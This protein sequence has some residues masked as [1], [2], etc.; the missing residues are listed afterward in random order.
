MSLGDQPRFRLAALPTPLQEA[1]RLRAA[2]GGHSRCPRIFI[3]RDDL[4]GLAFGGNKTRKL[5]YLV[6]DA[7]QQQATVLVTTGAAQSN[8]ARQTAA[9]ACVA[10]LRSVLVLLSDT[11]EPPVQGNLLLDR[12]LGAEV[13]VI[14]SDRSAARERIDRI[15]AD[16][17]HGGERPYWIPGGGSSPIGAFGYVA[18]TLEL[19][20]QC[21]ALDVAPRWLYYASG[22]RGTQAGLVLGAKMFSASFGLQG[23]AISPEQPD[24][25]PQAIQ[26]VNQAAALLGAEMQVSVDDLV[27]NPNYLGTGYGIGTAA[28]RE[29][30][31]LLAR[32]EGILLDPVYTAKA[33]AGL[34]D[35]IRRGAI[36]PAES[37]IFLHSG[38]APALFAAA[39]HHDLGA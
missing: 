38:G 37:V 28:S 15:V 10:G 1:T 30:I 26:V 23:I 34:I 4:T 17:A 14:P 29:A 11:G 33:M 39:D 27:T 3:K 32:Q 13:H 21:V 31:S 16:L 12:I 25:I 19:V 8:H 20:T 35:H 6:A 36:D 18:A 24:G 7:L 2:L 5:E 9:A 22:S